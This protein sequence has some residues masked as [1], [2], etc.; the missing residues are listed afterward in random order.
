MAN[1]LQAEGFGFRC[2]MHSLWFRERER[3][4]GERERESS[5]AYDVDADRRDD[6]PLVACQLFQTTVY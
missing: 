5:I 2:G 1:V 4:E 3:E 6:V